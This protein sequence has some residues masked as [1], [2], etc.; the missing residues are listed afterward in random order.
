MDAFVKASAGSK[1]YQLPP[2]LE[3]VWKDVFSLDKTIVW[4]PGEFKLY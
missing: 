2:A 1:L 4:T 3:E